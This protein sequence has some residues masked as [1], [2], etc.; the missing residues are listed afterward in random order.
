MAD[1]KRDLVGAWI[2]AARDDLGS[3][4]KLISG[5]PAFPGTSLYHSQQCAEKALKAFL[6]Q[7][8]REFEKTH[9]LA[10]LLDL[11][12][13]MDGRF[14]VLAETAVS[15]TPYATL[16]RYPDEVGPADMGE[17]AEGIEM[18]RA[19]LSFVLQVLG[20]GQG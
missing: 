2:Q 14:R 9:N 4:E 18:A 10:V 15:L 1:P 11:C 7:V 20:N 19:V 16:Y 6:L 5:E 8:G 13:D 3:A 17:A 12:A